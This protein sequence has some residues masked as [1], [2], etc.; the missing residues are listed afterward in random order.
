MRL[1]CANIITF[2]ASCVNHVQRDLCEES[3]WQAIGGVSAP[4]A[5]E[6]IKRL[7]WIVE[8]ST[9]QIRRGRENRTGCGCVE[10]LVFLALTWRSRNQRSR[11]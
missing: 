4:S 10:L 3:Q 5:R 11:S 8:E 2:S 9:A 6:E 7:V 1:L